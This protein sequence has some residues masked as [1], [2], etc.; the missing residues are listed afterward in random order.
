M[1]CTGPP[2]SGHFP[3]GPL[4]L[5]GLVHTCVHCHLLWSCGGCLTADCGSVLKVSVCPRIPLCVCYFFP[6][7]YLH[8]MCRNL[9][10][11]LNLYFCLPRLAKFRKSFQTYRLHSFTFTSSLWLTVKKKVFLGFMTARGSKYDPDLSFPQQLA[12]IPTLH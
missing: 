9:Y 5:S 12:S 7:F 3:H 6:L 2:G 8:S 11:S 4:C 10:F 1:T